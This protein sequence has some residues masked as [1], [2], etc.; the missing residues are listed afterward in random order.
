[1]IL[2][3]TSS[4][5]VRAMVHLADVGDGTPTKVD[6]IARE[7][8]VPRNYLSKILHTLARAGFLSSMRGPGG[9]FTMLRQPSS[10][11]LLDIIRQFDGRESEHA[12]LMGNK[13]CEEDHPCAAHDRWAVVKSQVLTFLSETT[14]LDL[15]ASQRHTAPPTDPG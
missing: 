14:I 10:I 5:A 1:M 7:L 3:Q 2:S 8:E 12:C 6:D 15:L 11:R 4:Y 13:P 9:G